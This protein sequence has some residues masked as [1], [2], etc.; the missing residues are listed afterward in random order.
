VAIEPMPAML[1]QLA[2]DQPDVK[3]LR[4]SAQSLPLASATIDAVIC[5]QSF[6]WFATASTLGEIGRVLKPGGL[7]GLIWNVRDRSVAWVES[8]ARLVDR[9]EGDAPRYDNGEWRTAFPAPGF[10]PLHERVA[11]HSHTGTAEQVIVERTAST[12]F[13]AAMPENERL[14][15][16][17]R[18][19]ALI[20]STPD[21]AGK[22]NVAMPYVTRMYWCYKDA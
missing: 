15:L 20:D 7:L 2:L 19:R 21:L 10:G 17:D 3:V 5:A 22:A 12:S 4:A 18:V 11:A 9:Y 13:V 8:L 6:H 1:A 16:L 14:H